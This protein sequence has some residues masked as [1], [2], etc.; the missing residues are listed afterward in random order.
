MKYSTLVT[1]RRNSF[2]SVITWIILSISTRIFYNYII[3]APRW[4]PGNLATIDIIYSMFNILILVIIIVHIV[5]FLFREIEHSFLSEG[6]IIRRFLPLIKV[7][8]IWF[9]W[10]GG[11]F[12]I[13]DGLHINTTSIL[14]GTG[15]A[16]V[17]LAIA[18]RDIIT[19]LFGSL[20]IL[21]SRT[22]EIGEM[23]RVQMKSNVAYEW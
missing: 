16:G 21:L 2:F 23:I 7:T 18:S 17:L 19:N 13:L 1:S 4:T 22:F 5:S 12:S 3:G 8:T 11:I 10:I 6:D 20:S 15:I 14:T 9:I